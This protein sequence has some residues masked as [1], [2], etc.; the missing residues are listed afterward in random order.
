MYSSNSTDE[1]WDLIVK[2]EMFKVNAECALYFACT[3]LAALFERDC[4][5]FFLLCHR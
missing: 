4:V 2:T 5:C 3:A 1:M